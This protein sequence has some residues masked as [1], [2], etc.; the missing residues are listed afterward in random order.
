MGGIILRPLLVNEVNGY[1]KKLFANDLLLTYLSIEGEISNF[2]HHYS[3]H[4]YFSLKDDKSRIKCVMF[5]GDNQNLDFKPKDGNKVVVTG[6][7]SI[8]EKDGSYQVYVKKMAPLGK[9]DLHKAFEELKAK[10]EKEGLFSSEH[11]K[12]LPRFPKKI[13][14]VTSSTGAAIRDMVSII[15][16]RFPPCDILIYPALVQG[17]QAPKDIIKGLKYLES[18]EDVDLIITG[19]GGGSFEELFPFS[20]EE[21][22]RYIFSMKKPV[23]SAVGHETDFSISDFVADIRAATPSMAAELAVPDKRA[24]L[25]ELKSL[26]YGIIRSVDDKLNSLDNELSS[27]GRS[28]KFLNPESILR[29][30]KLEIDSILKEVEFKLIKKLMTMDKKLTTIKNRINL[31]NPSIPLEKGYGIIY[32]DLG[33]IVK[34]VSRINKDDRINIRLQDGS[35]KTLVLEKEENNG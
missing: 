29:D 3:G 24:L 11:K 12:D 20:D 7:V 17:D 32:D 23:I 5:K 19:R 6:S 1:I 16:R 26:G 2:T 27:H 31:L 4:M 30:R 9:G 22:A 34:S 8:Y 18:R 15:K 13:G 35:I 10:L 33:N 28:L 14:I 21:L 25:D